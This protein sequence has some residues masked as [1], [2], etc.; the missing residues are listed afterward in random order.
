MTF[1][2]Q[3]MRILVWINL[4]SGVILTSSGAIFTGLHTFGTGTGEVVSAVLGVAGVIQTISAGIL[5][6]Q[7][8]KAQAALISAKAAHLSVLASTSQLKDFVVPDSLK[9]AA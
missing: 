1:N 2:P 9:A 6:L 8:V 4:I 5:Q 3:V 7:S